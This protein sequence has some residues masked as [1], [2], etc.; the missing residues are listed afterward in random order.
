MDRP[1]EQTSSVREGIYEPRGRYVPCGGRPPCERRPAL[2]PQLPRLLS[3]LPSFPFPSRRVRRNRASPRATRVRLPGNRPTL[4]DECARPRQ[5]GLLPGERAQVSDRLCRRRP[6][7]E[8]AFLYTRYRS[9][10]RPIVLVGSSYSASLSLVIASAETP[11][12]AVAAFSPG[13]HLRGIA[14]TDAVTG[15][16]VSTFV[17]AA[18]KEIPATRELV[19]R[20]PRGRVTFHAPRHE[21]AHGARCLWAKTAG[22]GEYWKAFLA[23]LEGVVE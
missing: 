21:G 23:F 16:S 10:G 15:L 20:A 14:V 5:R 4:G 18:Q 8:A 13:E 12:R 1:S 9:R 3:T 17:T 11:L 19:K 7:I 6:D 2:R 22:S